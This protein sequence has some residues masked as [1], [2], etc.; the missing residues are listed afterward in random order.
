ME[1]ALYEQALEITLRK[2]ELFDQKNESI[3][4]RNPAPEG[5]VLHEERWLKLTGAA[6]TRIQIYTAAKNAEKILP[7]YVCMH[8]GGF[9][10][11]NGDFDD[12]YCRLTALNVDCKVINVDYRLAPEFQFPYQL[13]ECYGAIKWAVRHAEELRIDPTRIMVGGHSAGAGLS[14][15][16]CAMAAQRKEFKLCGQ[17]LDYPP[18][19]FRDPPLWTEIPAG[20]DLYN[21]DNGAF[22]NLCYLKNNED[23]FDPMAST[24]LVQDYTGFPPALLVLAEHDA[25]TKPALAY[26][27]NLKKAGIETEV[28]VFAGCSHGFMTLP[29]NGT[30][31]AF[32]E[33]WAL[34]WKFMR[35]H[36]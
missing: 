35:E 33:G 19:D 8:G 13:E 2:R 1:Q 9:T 34:R 18:V 14:T 30:P 7:L 16:L 29:M 28:H 22:F 23:R 26:G 25:L 10:C 12:K 36:Y 20:L 15:G 5:S 11:G 6:D 32:D 27:E 3:V 17:V 4:L 31:E 24:V 21:K